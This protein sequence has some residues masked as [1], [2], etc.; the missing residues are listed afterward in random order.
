MR[1]SPTRAEARIW[2]WLRGRR[3]DGCK[4]KRQVPIGRYIVDFYCA[5]LQL[6]IELDGA[7]HRYPVMADYDDER[8]ETLRIQGIQLIR[9]PNEL[10]IRDS[11]MVEEMVRSAIARRSITS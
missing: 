6:A 9:V 7:H 4:F 5:E 3:F 11:K 2:S 8:T 1:R 10:L